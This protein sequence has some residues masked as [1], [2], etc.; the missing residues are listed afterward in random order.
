L[1]SSQIG[2]FRNGLGFILDGSPVG[3][4]VSQQFGQRYAALST[5]LL[6]AV[7][8]TAPASLRPSD[9]DLVTFWLE[10]NDSQNYLV[11]GD[12]AVRTRKDQLS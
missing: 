3:H 2:P 11:L 5:A 4:A 9:R 12:P 6:S 7:S 8:P 10:R 1:T